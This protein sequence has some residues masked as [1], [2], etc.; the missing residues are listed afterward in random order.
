MF[1]LIMT[2]EDSPTEEVRADE[3]YIARAFNGYLYQNECW[4]AIS[5]KPM[6]KAELQVAWFQMIQQDYENDEEM[7]KNP[8]DVEKWET[9]QEWITR[10][11]RERI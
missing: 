9:F 7:L 10:K 4:M 5:D 3:D 1:K 11:D 2:S 6:K 8:P